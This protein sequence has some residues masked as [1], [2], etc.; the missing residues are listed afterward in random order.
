[1]S[2]F[3][4]NSTDSQYEENLLTENTPNLNDI[5][6]ETDN[7]GFLKITS[8][9]NC[10]NDSSD[11]LKKNRG[12]VSNYK[13]P[14][15]RSLEYTQEYT[16]LNI[17]NDFTQEIKKLR[18]FVSQEG[19]LIRV[20]YYEGFPLKNDHDLIKSNWYVS[21]HRK[22]NAFKSRWG[23]GLESFGDIFKRYLIESGVNYDTLFERLNKT[24]VYYFFIRNTESNR[25]VCKIR[26]K[27]F[28]FLIGMLSSDDKYHHGPDIDSLT[29]I[30]RAKELNFNTKEE[31]QTWV[32]YID[33]FLYQG[34]IGFYENGTQ[35]KIVNSKYNL[36]SQIRGNESSI[37]FRY[38]NV[39]TNTVSVRLLRELYPEH[40]DN[41]ILYESLI[42]NIAKNI[43]NTYMTRFI[44]KEHIVTDNNSY[45]IM[46]EAHGKHILN[47]NV[48][49]TFDVIFNILSEQKFVS[50]LNSLLKQE[51]QKQK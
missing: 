21:T 10:T 9:K 22:L 33:P 44:K 20:F 47:R 15:F 49:V 50:T 25:V 28:V 1:M 30:P 29:E 32:Q 37:K 11:F 7:D 43:H 16:E 2:I 31:I 36:Y 51:M 27:P 3:L 14:I 46:K 35:V 34:I 12:V 6:E 17:P 26:E 40:N 19:T 8:Y 42:Y 45:R 4:E 41:F 13:G 48:K 5:I 24:C 38:L 18:L 23:G 39:R